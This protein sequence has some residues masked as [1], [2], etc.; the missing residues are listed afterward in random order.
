LSSFILTLIFLSFSFRLYTHGYDFFA[1]GEAVVYHLYSR[2]HRKTIQA[3][4]TAE[5]KQL[6]EQSRD[7][8]KS[9]FIKA[10][11]Q[12]NGHDKPIND[13]VFSNEVIN[14]SFYGLGTIRSKGEY[15]KESG[16]NFEKQEINHDFTK[17][18]EYV[19][20]GNY[21]DFPLTTINFESFSLV[22]DELNDFKK[23]ILEN[24]SLLNNS[25]NNNNDNQ[26]KKI[27][28]GSSKALS[29]ILKFL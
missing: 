14:H 4:E 8:V 13:T 20:P 12:E 7:I 25:N 29:N 16:I 26:N 15:E 3:Q 1:P 5:R 19:I 18:M 27:V 21:R 28:S 17:Q 24:V 2:Q 10:P 9:F 22:E 11:E 6:K 23:Q